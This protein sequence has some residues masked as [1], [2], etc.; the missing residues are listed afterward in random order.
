MKILFI[1]GN[2]NKLKEAKEI[3]PEI[4]GCEIDLPEIQELDGKKIVEEKLSEAIKQKPGINLIVEDLSL[5][6]NGM[7]GLPGPLIKWFLKSVGR[8]GV[9]KMAKLFGDQKAEAKVTLGYADD[10]GNIKYFEGIIEGKIVEPRGE[11]EFG[12]DPVFQPD[13]YNKTFAEM[14]MEEKNKI[15]HRKIALEKLREYLKK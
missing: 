11:S 7:N 10:K 14:G 1:T 5:V 6:I 2:L 9:A 3:M 12:W 15:S 8:E 4:E 13:G